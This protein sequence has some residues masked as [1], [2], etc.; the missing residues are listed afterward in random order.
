VFVIPTSSIW[1]NNSYS[2]IWVGKED[3]FLT[4]I[5]IGIY[6]GV[7]LEVGTLDYFMNDK[8]I[9]DYVVNILK[10]AYFGV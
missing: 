1:G 8:Y 9:K 10:D 6:S 7:C 5:Y 3:K 2:G 4:G